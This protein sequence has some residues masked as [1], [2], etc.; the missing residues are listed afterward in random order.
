MLVG[1][2]LAASELTAVSDNTSY[3]FC[4]FTGIMRFRSSERSCKW[5]PESSAAQ[6]LSG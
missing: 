3:T 6:R 4:R 5:K 2:V 1:L